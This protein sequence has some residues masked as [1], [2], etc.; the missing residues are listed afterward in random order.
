MPDLTAGIIAPTSPVVAD[1]PPKR[2]GPIYLIDYLEYT[3]TY[4]RGRWNDPAEC[5][6]DGCTELAF[7]PGIHVWDL[8]SEHWKDNDDPDTGM[9][10]LS[11]DDKRE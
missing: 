4:F 11:G 5:S 1:K 2:H 6:E 9:D 3:D 8:C 10:D 7:E